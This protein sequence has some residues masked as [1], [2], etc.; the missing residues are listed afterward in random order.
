MGVH[1]KINAHCMH[2]SHIQH[3]K[4]HTDRS[5]AVEAIAL[6]VNE[7]KPV[8]GRPLGLLAAW[9]QF[10]AHVPAGDNERQSHQ[11]IKK[12]LS[13]EA[14]YQTRVDARRELWETGETN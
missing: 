13:G 8:R 10:A 7:Q 3:G 6:E 1:K 2:A 14:Y 9:L 12:E 4:C 11:L 5:V